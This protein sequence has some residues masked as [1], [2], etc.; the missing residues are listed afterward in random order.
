MEV[1]DSS[2]EVVEAYLLYI[3]PKA[4]FQKSINRFLLFDLFVDPR[5]AGDHETAK[6]RQLFTV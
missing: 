5:M 6:A 1:R 2:G 3:S 4:T